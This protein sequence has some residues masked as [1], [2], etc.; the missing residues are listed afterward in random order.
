MPRWDAADR[1]RQAEA[2]QRLHEM[3]DL[4]DAASKALVEEYDEN[5]G[6][7]SGAHIDAERL[8]T[9]M[10]KIGWRHGG[11]MGQDGDYIGLDD[12]DGKPLHIGQVIRMTGCGENGDREDYG[13]I[14]YMAP[15]VLAKS[16]SREGSYD[17]IGWGCGKRMS[18]FTL[19]DEP[20]ATELKQKYAE[21]KKAQW[22]A[23]YGEE[24]EE[25]LPGG[26]AQENE[27]S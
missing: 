6:G 25:A 21:W 15:Q 13:R 19:V 20:L 22:Q 4:A 26:W 14:W 8:A 5:S 10:E 1:K 23:E 24:D 2:Q 27:G 18:E 11:R 9:E 3:F 16:L 7:I 17:V 12:Q